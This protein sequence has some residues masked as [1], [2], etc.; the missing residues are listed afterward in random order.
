MVFQ[1]RNDLFIKNNQIKRRDTEN[2]GQGVQAPHNAQPQ[3]SAQQVVI[4]QQV[5]PNMA[6]QSTSGGWGAKLN[7][8]LSSLGVGSTKA[9]KSTTATPKTTSSSSTSSTSST[10]ATNSTGSL[11]LS[12]EVSM[13]NLKTLDGM[14]NDWDAKLKENVAKQKELGDTSELKTQMMI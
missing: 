6:T 10:G 8:V 14:V 3:S 9:A 5:Q 2:N 12:K 1:V 11:N 4:I 7:S 13:D